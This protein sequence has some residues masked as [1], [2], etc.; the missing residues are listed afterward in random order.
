ME[1]G[2]LNN[3]NCILSLLT[4][5]RA[6]FR[7]LDS[8]DILKYSSWWPSLSNQE[9]Q[10]NAEAIIKR[11]KKCIKLL[12]RSYCIASRRC[13]LHKFSHKV[14]NLG[15]KRCRTKEIKQ[16]SFRTS[17]APSRWKKEFF[18]SNFFWGNQQNTVWVKVRNCLNIQS[19]NGNYRIFLRKSM[20][21][22]TRYYIDLL[23]KY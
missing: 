6:C 2:T 10:T 16:S 14:R 9:E 18:A 12:T 7:S 11:S 5:T 4:R 17:S 22:H 19:G 1:D 23:Y 13:F 15:M 8:E 20:K 21:T 3:K